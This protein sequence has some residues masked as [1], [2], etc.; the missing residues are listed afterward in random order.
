MYHMSLPNELLHSIVEYLAYVPP[1][2]GPHPEPLHRHVS[3]E[4]VALSTVN[5]RIRQ[6]CLPFLFAYIQIRMFKDV[7]NLRDIQVDVLQRFT[8]N[9]SIF[10]I[11]SRPEEGDQIL[12][13][14]MPYLKHLTYVQ[15]TSCHARIPLLKALLGHPTIMTILVDKLPHESLAYDVDLSKVVLEEISMGD[16]LSSTVERY[17]DRGMRL[18]SLKLVEPELLNEDFGFKTFKGLEELRVSTALGHISFSW[19]S[20]LCS[21]NP[22][23][24]ELSLIDG[25]K[26]YFRRH[27]PIFISSF[28]DR[29]RQQGLTENFDIDFVSLRRLTGHSLQ[30]WHVI[31]LTI[32]T[33]FRSSSLVEILMLISSSF[34]KLKTLILNT[35]HHKASY[36]VD[37]LVSTF[38]RFSSLRVLY[39]HR[40]RKRLNFGSKLESRMPSV[41][42]IGSASFE[43]LV[44]HAERGLLLFTSLLAKQVRSL[45]SIYIED[46]GY[47]H[48]E[49]GSGT[50]WRLRGWLHVLN[51]NRELVGRLTRSRNYS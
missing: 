3:P 28:V 46:L 26:L 9:L 49:S 35:N 27:T 24:N 39:L 29:I 13:Q 43:E 16:P 44:D 38:A 2:P 34:P 12:S 5:R 30:D 15:I 11:Y 17:L 8:K 14:T 19:L 40:V 32:T 18:K 48:E 10:Y 20:T 41:Q 4:L 47:E 31:G 23:L 22:T 6:I 1:L 37:D 33:T 21:I 50:R 45:D 36:R 51:G 42:Q 25:R 7:E